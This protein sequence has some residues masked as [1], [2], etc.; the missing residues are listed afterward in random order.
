MKGT[1]I[2]GSTFGAPTTIRLR[3]STISHTFMSD[4]QNPFYGYGNRGAAT[5][6]MYFSWLLMDKLDTRNL[7]RK[8][9]IKIDSLRPLYT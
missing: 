9:P 8:K 2:H 4:H 1:R 3:R 7:L 5:S 6:L